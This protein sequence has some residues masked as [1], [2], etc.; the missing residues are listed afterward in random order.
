MIGEDKTPQEFKECVS[1]EQLEGV[2]QNVQKEIRETVI[3]A[4][5]E[6][7]MELKLTNAVEWVDK[8]IFELTDRVINLE[9][10]PVPPKDAT[11]SNDGDEVY[12]ADGNIET[13]AIMQ[14]RLRRR[15]HLNTAG[16]GGAH[17]HRH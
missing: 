9:N 3:K 7:V 12:H 13:V 15:L 17:H 5:T 10:R 4:V 14:N 2:V 6:A 16:M 11:G 1:Q 8:R